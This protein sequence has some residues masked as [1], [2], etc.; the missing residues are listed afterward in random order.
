MEIWFQISWHL[1]AS[2]VAFAAG[3]QALREAL[4][5]FMRGLNALAATSPL[6]MART[7][8]LTFLLV[9]TRLLASV[10]CTLD[11]IWCP[12]N[13][14]FEFWSVIICLTDWTEKV[15]W[16]QPSDFFVGCFQSRSKYLCRPA[17][18]ICIP[19]T[20]YAQGMNIWV[21]ACFDFGEAVQTICP[22]VLGQD[23]YWR[24]NTFLP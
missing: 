8:V 15:L 22:R 6:N 9:R 5:E 18:K 10:L 13:Q 21:V 4:P 17:E 7:T 12:G 11:Q 20:H 23:R 1:F 19:K 2:L 16:Q 3:P 24:D 14:L